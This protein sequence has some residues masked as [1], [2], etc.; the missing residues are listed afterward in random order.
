MKLVV[1]SHKPCWR[2]ESSPTGYA[3][4]GG[5]PI[6]MRSLAELFDATTLLV[7]VGS[8]GSGGGNGGAGEEGGSA[9]AGPGIRV[10]PL[11]PPP[12]RGAVRKL[13]FPFWILQ[14]ARVL[15]R[16]VRR[17][18]AVHAPIPGDVGTAGILLSLA[19][20]KRLFVRHCGNW[21][22][23]KTAA[24]RF[25]KW[26]MESTAGGRRVMLATGGSAGPPSSRNEH[27][28][29]VFASSLTRRE[30][31]RYGHPRDDWRREGEGPRLLIACRQERDKGVGAAIGSLLLVR[32]EFPGATLDVVGDGSALP[33]LRALAAHLGLGSAVAF[34]GQLDHGAVLDR[35]SRADLFCYPTSSSDGFPKVV[36]EALAC[37]LPV[38]AT[39]VSVL[40]RLLEDGAGVLIDESSP[41]AVADGV[42]SCLADPER[43]RSL[44]RHAVATARS[45]SLETW[46]DAIGERLA[47]AW[48]SLK[49]A[50]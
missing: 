43:Y 40:P 26:L 9:L 8:S 42:R 25:W 29:W 18:D 48:G 44:S 36:L 16:E 15:F 37:G 50:S 24:D 11:T 22:A 7:P 27:V 47:G 33:E 28:G 41:E 19:M 2:S 35:M 10:I 49:C 5:F 23:P 30:L 4:D 21:L 46:R 31:E 39:R 1:I 38:V 14:N 13:L 45:Y 6:Q 32:R 17:A 12:G 3:T 20:G 34:H